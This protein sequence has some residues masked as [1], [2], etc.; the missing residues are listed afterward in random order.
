MHLNCSESEID[1]NVKIF[2]NSFTELRIQNDTI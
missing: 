1:D 2:I